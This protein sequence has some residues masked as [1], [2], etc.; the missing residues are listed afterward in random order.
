MEVLLAQL[1]SCVSREA[2]DE[3]AVNFC[4][5]A[6]KAARRR[7]AR[8]LCDVPRGAT[9]LLPCWARIAAS[10][11]SVFPDIPQGGWAQCRHL[12]GVTSACC[13]AGTVIVGCTPYLCSRRAGSL[14]C[15]LP[16][17]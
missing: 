2:C 17:G 12:C 5:M 13:S 11:A 16:L 1:P 9:H 15:L 6:S 10:L 8:A 14:R 4:F 7:L 3:V